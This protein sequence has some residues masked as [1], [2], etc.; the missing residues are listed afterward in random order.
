[1]PELAE[2]ER[3]RRVWAQAAGMVVVRVAVRGGVRCLR[4]VSAE[5]FEKALVGR[6]LSE[7]LA[8]GKQLL[9]RFGEAAWLSVHLGMAGRLRRD[10]PELVPGRHDHLVVY[11]ERVALVYQDYRQFGRV[12][13][14]EG[15]EPPRWWRERPAAL[16]GEGLTVGA[17][18]AFLKRRG[19]APLKAVLLMQERFPGIGNWMADE[20]LW[21]A[22]IHPAQPAGSLSARKERDLYAAIGE[23]V[24]GAL[25]FI[26]G[27]GEDP[28]ESWLFAHRWRDG[29]RCPVSGK[30]LVRERIGGRTTCYAPG[31]QRLRE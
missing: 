12:R 19:R 17:M 15:A 4:E 2:V 7:S 25:H 13:L 1:M 18:R 24:R 14:D 20:I 29:G 8:H 11:G 21:R 9:F 16:D 30:E 28:P 10:V 22:R 23:V 26:A 6:E 31:R 27:Q 3:A 5:V